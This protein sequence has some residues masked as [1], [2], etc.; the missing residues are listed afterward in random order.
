MIQLKKIDI[1]FFCYV[2]ITTILLFLSWNDS[3]KYLELFLTR[4]LLLGIGMVLIY[5]DSKVKNTLLNLLRNC[6]P[7]LF[8][9]LFYT[10]TVFYNK[11]FF[12]NLDKYLIKLDLQLFG[13]QPSVRFSEYFSNPVFSELMYVGYFALYILIISFV[14]ITYFKLK[15]DSEELFFK[16]AASML[17]FYLFFCF[18]PAAGPQFHFASPEK[19]LPTAFLFDEIMHL[20]QKA[21]QPTGA[22][23]SSH[24]GLSLIV[25][26]LFRKRV[27]NYFKIAIP[28]VI[29]LILSTVYI[30]AHYAVDAIAGIISVPIVLFLSTFLYKNTPEYKL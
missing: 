24:V 23:P 1:L 29:L 16:L 25:L 18:F 9:M 30:K 19:D 10:E 13:F 12:S 26:V 5:F 22:F 27:P 15:K 21:E 11:L 28:F 2:F 14:F 4:G 7:V 8:S 6:Y 20:I 3:D 17:L